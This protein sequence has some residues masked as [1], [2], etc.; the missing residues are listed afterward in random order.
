IGRACAAGDLQVVQWELATGFPWHR[1]APLLAFK[2]GHLQ[3]LQFLRTNGCP[4]R[5]PSDYCC[6]TAEG[7]HLDVL[8][9]VRADGCD[10]DAR[11][12]ISAVR[13]GH[14]SVLPWARDNGCLADAE[15]FPTVAHT[16]SLET[17]HRLRATGCLW[18]FK[19]VW[20]VAAEGG[21]LAILRWLLAEGKP[22]FAERSAVSGPD[23]CARAVF[24]GH[25]DALKW[26]RY[27]GVPWDGK[28]C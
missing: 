21:R 5:S 26:L 14:V 7:G 15:T 10:W 16:G 12:R 17:L 1:S 9:L 3:L 4:W 27:N 20:T 8:Q 25:W 2:F 19:D 18:D 22:V 24:Y 23:I 13:N 28:T 11:T 6:G